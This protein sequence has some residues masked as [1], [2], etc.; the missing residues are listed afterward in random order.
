MS[1]R[2]RG[3]VA[4]KTLVRRG[5]AATR[6]P[7]TP[8][9]TLAP[10][11]RS[12]TTVSGGAVR[13]ETV[14]LFDRA[15]VDHNR[16]PIDQY[17]ENT[18]AL[19]RLYLNVEP[20]PPE[21]GSLVLLGLMSAVESYFRAMFRG[22]IN[23]DEHASRLAEPQVVSFGAALHLDAKMLPEAVLEEYSFASA[24][25]IKD[26]IR[27]L[28]GIKGHLPPD[29]EAALLEFQKI[30]EMRH[31]CVHR[32]GKLGAKN[33]IKLGLGTHRSML[34]K[35]LRLDRPALELVGASLRSFVKT[36]NNFVF[37]ALMERTVVNRV[38]GQIATPYSRDWSWKWQL[39]RARFL[40]YYALFASF[41]DSVPSP[42]AK[43]VYESLRAFAEDR[44]RPGR[45]GRAGSLASQVT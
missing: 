18:N 30:C 5:D 32:F 24:K 22:V 39:D 29:V 38:D 7:S 45:V 10:S 41:V 1:T 35:P 6:G 28:G 4:K 21:M 12:I 25:N 14:P 43:D 9:I 31:C 44:V 40:R 8:V 23:V 27:E 3:N 42:T 20:M 17:I 33:A 2:P 36:I 11:F 34:E 15:H 19:N 37:G 16:S 26:A 13:V